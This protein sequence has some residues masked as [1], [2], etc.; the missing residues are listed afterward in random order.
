MKKDRM[1]KGDVFTLKIAQLDANGE[2]IA[3]VEENAVHVLSAAEGDT[4]KAKIIA[5]SRHHSRAHAKLEEVITPGESR[6]RPDCYR[7]ISDGGKCGGCVLMH[8]NKKAQKET[9]ERFVNLFLLSNGLPE[10]SDYFEAPNALAYRN[11][12]HFVV[13][14]GRKEQIV[15]GAYAPRSH[16]VISIRGCRVLRDGIRE[17]RDIIVDAAITC[18]VP[19]YPEKAGLR[20]VTIREGSDRTLAIDLVT[21]EGASSAVNALVRAIAAAPMVAGISRSINLSEGN[22]MRT[23][24]SKDLVGKAIVTEL[25]A[26][27]PLRVRPTD[28]LQL[29]SEVASNIYR[30]AAAQVP[31]KTVIWDLYAGIGTFGLVVAKERNAISLYGAEQNEESVLSAAENARRLGINAAYL[32]VDLRKKMP[33]EW[34]KPDV[35]LLNPPRRGLD[36]LIL[37]MLFKTAAK[38]LFY[39]SCSP[40]TFALDAKKLTAHGWTLQRTEAFDMLPQTSHVEILGQFIR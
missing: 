4:V 26:D 24:P 37:E 13:A 12:G 14:H 35:I 32:A 29:N 19:V 31:E 6:V 30:R 21:N 1:K 9:K 38:Q 36:K 10:L 11:K 28:F 20:Y 5:I 27:I 15:L 2:G 39:M 18:D 23:E 16:K 17:L 8:V 3:Y 22:S 7:A 34:Q 33:A 25:V 40:K